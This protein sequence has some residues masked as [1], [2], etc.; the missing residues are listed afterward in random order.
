MNRQPIFL[1]V[2]KQPSSIFCFLPGRIIGLWKEWALGGP[3]IIFWMSCRIGYWNEGSG[4]GG[5]G[6]QSSQLV[7][8][9]SPDIQES[10]GILVLR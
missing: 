4:H 8:S 5:S 3:G 9:L 6:L 1:V 2:R 10:F 7:P